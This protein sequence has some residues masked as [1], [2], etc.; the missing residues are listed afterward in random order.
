MLEHPEVA[1]RTCEE[2]QRWFYDPKTGKRSMRFGQPLPRKPTD[3]KPSCRGCPKCH[4][5]PL[6]K[7]S[8][9]AGARRTL[10]AKNWR[11]LDLF[12]EVQA[13]GTAG[14]KL[15]SLARRNLGLI[16][17]TLAEHERLNGFKLSALLQ[18]LANRPAL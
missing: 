17:R 6:D 5:L 12:Y 8:P 2:C 15:D 11:T 10:S 9:K 3:P 14:V 4:G 7:Q 13:A 18:V 1:Y 16:A